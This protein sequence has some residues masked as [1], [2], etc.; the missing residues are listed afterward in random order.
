MI[1]TEAGINTV[2]QY[3]YHAVLTELHKK[4]V[5]IFIK[6]PFGAF[7]SR[8]LIYIII[9]IAFKRKEIHSLSSAFFVS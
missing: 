9:L 8:F 7:R 3:K 2:S 4:Y 6:D 1:L 5:K